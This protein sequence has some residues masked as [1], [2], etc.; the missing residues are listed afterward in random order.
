MTET[1]IQALTLTDEERIAILQYWPDQLSFL[2]WQREALAGEIE[3]R[4]AQ[5]GQQTASN[6][7]REA[8]QVAYDQFPTVFGAPEAVVVVDPPIEPIE[9]LSEV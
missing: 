5:V 4:A 8:V 3:R 2:M 7:I 1:P 6:A 9:P